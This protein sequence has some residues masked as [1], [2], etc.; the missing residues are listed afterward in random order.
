MSIVVVIL[1]ALSWKKQHL[2]PALALVFFP[3]LKHRKIYKDGV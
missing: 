2:T 3:A 1:K